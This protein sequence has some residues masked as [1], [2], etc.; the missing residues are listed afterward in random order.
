M[1]TFLQVMPAYGELCVRPD[2]EDIAARLQRLE[3]MDTERLTAPAR[4]WMVEHGDLATFARRWD[5][6][7]ER[8]APA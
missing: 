3:H 8:V 2:V 1:Q 4:A 7:I 6:L 5:E